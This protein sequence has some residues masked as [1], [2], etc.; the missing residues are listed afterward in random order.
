MVITGIR[1]KLYCPKNILPIK[2]A[3]ELPSRSQSILLEIST[4]EGITGY[5]E[6]CP[7]A[8]VTGNDAEGTLPVVQALSKALL[9]EDPLNIARIHARMDRYYQGQSAAKAAFDIALHDILGK[10]AGLP[11]YRLLGGARREIESD[12]TV[13][14]AD[15]E[16][17]AEMAAGFVREGFR[18]LKIKA[19]LNVSEDL[20]AI[21][22]IREAV[23]PEIELR[24]D[25]NQGWS[26]K[27]TIAMMAQLSRYGIREVEQPVKAWDLDACRRI[28]AAISQDLMLD[29]SVHTPQDALRAVRAEAAD[30]IN[31]K[32]MKSSGIYPAAKINAIAE[33]AG[34]PCMV[35]CMGETRIGIAAAAALAAAKPNILLSDLD[36]Y[37][38]LEESPAIRGGFHQ[39]GSRITLLEEPG[40]GVAVDFDAL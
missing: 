32:L 36:G 29:E 23:G 11:L 31:I 35:G 33:A 22:R 37:R 4:D 24:I 10:K 21:A 39:E 7:F 15:P 3:L 17:M 16:L 2:I 6:A 40:L 27:E 8:P 25:A 34:V 18:I 26:A 1:S 13:G 19:G 14:I 30:Y 9:G 12:M 28:R 5:G 38:F 20:R